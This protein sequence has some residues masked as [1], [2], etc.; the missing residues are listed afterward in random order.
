M[1]LKNKI[2]ANI[3]EGTCVG[4]QIRELIQDIKFEINMIIIILIDYILL[5]VKLINK[6]H[7]NII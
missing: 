4:P 2:N 3:K 7:P 5:G 6:T 1:Y